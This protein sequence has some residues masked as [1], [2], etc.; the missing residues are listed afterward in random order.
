[1]VLLSEEKKQVLLEIA[2]ARVFLAYF[3]TGVITWYIV[4]WLVH[5]WNYTTVLS[6]PMLMLT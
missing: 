6:A 2:S 1:M 4:A 5:I 3:I